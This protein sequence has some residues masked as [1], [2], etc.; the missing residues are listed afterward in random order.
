MIRIRKA[1]ERGHFDTAGSTPTTR[2]PSATTTTR[3]PGLPLAAGH[4][5]R[6]SAA[7][8]RVRDARPS[9]HGDRHLRPG[10]KAATQGQPGQ[11]SILPGW[12]TPT[13]DRRDRVRHSEFNPSDKEW[14]HLYQIWLLPQRK[15]LDPS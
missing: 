15:G 7:R 10:G 9:G 4:Q 3:A 5:R 14:V 2:F 11:R 6:P 8:S 13:H 1:A 12:R